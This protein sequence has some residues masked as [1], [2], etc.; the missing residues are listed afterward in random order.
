MKAIKRTD[1]HRPSA[2]EPA[3]YEYVGIEYDRTDTIDECYSLNYNRQLIDSHRKMTGGKYSSHEHGGNC[4]ICGAH[5]IYTALFYHG[6]T[7]ECIHTGFDCAEKMMDCDPAA[8]RAFRKAI[9]DA[10][11]RKAGKNK[12]MAILA[13]LDL[14]RAWDFYTEDTHNSE[15]AATIADIVSN[16][17][18]Y[19]DC[20]E[21][22][23]NYIRSLIY[24]I[25]N[26]ERIEAERKAE[27]EAAENCPE[28]RVE[29]VGTVL[30]TEYRDTAY[31][32]RSVMTVKDDRGFLVWGSIPSSLDFFNETYEETVP[33]EDLEQ[34]ERVGWEIHTRDNGEHY[35][36]RERQR[37]LDKGDRV[38][39]V[40]KLT[41]SD[42]DEKF[43]F[44]KRP[45][46]AE[47]LS[48]KS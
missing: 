39:F 21:K 1:I 33:D 14:S 26:A 29:I 20:S 22:Q 15:Y 46:K 34:V 42:R 31:G 24:R 35:I 6:P 38:K 11:E 17:V 45:T 25:D 9:H 36:V 27:R 3:D 18:R 30:K 41:P 28:G 12:A 7:N 2:I 37:S 19:G 48:A 47:L 40:A 13:D 32:V 4:H 5:C 8:F 16:I 10:R 44:Y 23:V 43:G